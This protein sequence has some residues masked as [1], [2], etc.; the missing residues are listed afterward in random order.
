MGATE[1]AEE[2]SIVSV[3]KEAVVAMEAVVGSATSLAAEEEQVAVAGVE[4]A[5]M[6][7]ARRT[8]VLAQAEGLCWG[9]SGI[10]DGERRV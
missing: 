5:V 8:A 3:A 4:Q 6:A 2:E 10:W 1:A 9:A 7:E